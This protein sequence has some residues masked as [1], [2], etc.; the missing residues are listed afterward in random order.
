MVPGTARLGKAARRQTILPYTRSMLSRYNSAAMTQTRLKPAAA[1]IDGAPDPTFGSV[2]M[3]VM[4]VMA[5]ARHG[6]A[7][8]QFVNLVLA[9]NRAG[10]DQ[11]AVIRRNP[12]RADALRAGGVDPLELAFGSWTDVVTVPALKRE[13]ASYQPDIVLTWMNRASKM[14]PTGE[15][16]RLGR[17]G[18]YYDVKY[19]RRC[20]H[21]IGN[22][23]D[24]VEHVV[25]HGWPR[26]R[27]HLMLNFA[28][29]RDLP[30]ISRATLNTPED[31]VVIV[32]LGRLHEA[33]A[34]DT[35]LQALAVEQRPYLW[36]AGEGPLRRELE[37]LA[38][39]LGIADRVRFL[40]WRD[41]REALYAAADICIVPSR[42]E[43]FGSV[44]VEAWANRLPLVATASAGP[45]ALIH[46]DQDGLLVPIDDVP[47]MAASLT[48]LMDEPDLGPRLVEA[49]QRCY[50]AD[51]TEAAAVARWL[52]LF[53]RLL[54][55]RAGGRMATR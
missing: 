25:Q 14:F 9:L 46:D 15:F 26:A 4:Q 29:V 48:R 2:P 31:A 1:E 43:P 50:Q 23:Q 30:A 35:L 55:T 37:L 13:V 17:L 12:A 41:D 3:R 16:L 49:G 36:L 54:A 32:A 28:N 8:T 40:G 47:A 44:T 39:T 52:G 51:F 22:T 11:R 42:H 21:L 10:L 34:F 33:K 6:G 20:N 18:G 7:E 45:T 19:Y 38:G 24:I 27:A 53:R 5:G